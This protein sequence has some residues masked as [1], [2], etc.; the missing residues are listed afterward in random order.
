MP[1]RLGAG[2]PRRK[3]FLREYRK[4][5]GLTLERA[6]ERFVEAGLDDMSE[7]QLSRIETG[8]QPY[9]Q[10]FL[11]AAADAYG[12]DP[13]S[14]LMRDP[15]DPEGIWSIWDNALPGQRREIVDHAKIT[16]K[17]QAS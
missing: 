14:L 16:V 17:K 15:G 3:T 9:T 4:K 2:G 10:D 1:R 5:A 8:K 11:E 12:T 6:I 7:A 13:A